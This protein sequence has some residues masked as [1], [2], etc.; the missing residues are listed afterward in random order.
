MGF[1]KIYGTEQQKRRQLVAG[2]GSQTI[3]LCAP[4]LH[5]VNTPRVTSAALAEIVPHGILIGLGN[6]HLCG[7]P[8]VNFG[9]C[10]APK[11]DPVSESLSNTCQSNKGE[12]NG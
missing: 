4:T 8:F 2:S 10:V 7:K 1:I 12:I 3:A 9:A 11:A 6:N 5:S